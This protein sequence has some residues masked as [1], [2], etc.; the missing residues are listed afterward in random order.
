MT[1]SHFMDYRSLYVGTLIF[2]L[3]S[4]IAYKIDKISLSSS[5]SSI[6]DDE[7]QFFSLFK[8]NFNPINSE[9]NSKKSIIERKSSKIFNSVSKFTAY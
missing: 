6:F 9:I 1:L 7:I 8:I 5:I 3:K 4:C 2:P